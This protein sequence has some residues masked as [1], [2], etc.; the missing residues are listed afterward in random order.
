MAPVSL[1]SWSALSLGL[2]CGRLCAHALDRFRFPTLAKGTTYFLLRLRQ[3]TKGLQHCCTAATATAT[4]IASTCWLL[5]QHLVALPLTS[6]WCY[7][8]TSNASQ[9]RLITRLISVSFF[10]PSSCA[11]SQPTLGSVDTSRSDN[12]GHTSRTS[13][14]LFYRGAGRVPTSATR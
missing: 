4:A 13:A 7:R 9:V 3:E 10:L 6:R 1:C 12:M 14:H 8:S 5:L 11:A 2:G